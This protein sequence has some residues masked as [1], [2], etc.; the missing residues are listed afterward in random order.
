[1]GGAAPRSI[2]RWGWH[3]LDPAWA[4]RVVRDA[5][6][7]AGDLVLDIGAGHGALTAPLL[8]TGA[9]VVAVEA[10][11]G[12]AAHLRRRFGGSLT[13]VEADA[14]D[15]RLPRRRFHVVANPPFGA[16]SGLLRRLVH[17]GSRLE[18][19]HLV[20][21]TQAIRRWAGPDAPGARR[22]R[23]D[24]H[25]ELGP[26]LPRSAFRPAPRVDSRVL[27]LRRR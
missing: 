11:P 6:V 4:E 22:W 20:L 8:A 27:V 16:T 1:M 23:A 25:A 13:V 18:Q 21:Q 5:R 7:G 3:Q 10:H 14:R 15:L 17:H 12:R 26:H 24:F 9:R 19:A 2:E